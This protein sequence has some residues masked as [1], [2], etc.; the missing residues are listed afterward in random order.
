ME[1]VN[2]DLQIVK[3]VREVQEVSPD[4]H[5]NSVPPPSRNS[6][7][8]SKKA[9]DNCAQLVKPITYEALPDSQGNDLSTTI[10]FKNIESF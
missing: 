2:D 8:Q 7:R 10:S 9:W 4:S 1:V 6:K 3:V 5:M